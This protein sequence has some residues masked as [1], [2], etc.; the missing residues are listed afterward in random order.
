[1]ICKL[2]VALKNCYGFFMFFVLKFYEK[3]NNSLTS[4]DISLRTLSP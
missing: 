1:M 3:Q 2:F 4:G